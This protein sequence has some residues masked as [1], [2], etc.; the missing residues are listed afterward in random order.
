MCIIVYKP[1]GVKFPNDE[2]IENC[3]NHNSHGAGFMYPASDGV[4]IHKGFMSLKDFNEGIKPYKYLTDTPI[5]MHFRI[6]T[7]AGVIPEMTQPFPVTSKTKKLKRLDTMGQV[8]VAHNG[9]ISMTNDAK[10]ISDTAL[11]IKRYMSYLIKD[12]EYYKDPRIA[13]MIEQMIGSKMAVLSTDGHCE[14]LGSGWQEDGGIWYSNTTYKSYKSYSFQGKSA[15]YQGSNYYGGYYGSSYGN[16]YGS[17]YQ[18]W[19]DDDYDDYNWEGY[20]DSKTWDSYLEK[21]N[22]SPEEEDMYYDL[23]EECE[24][25]IATKGASCY[26]CREVCNCYAV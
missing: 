5:V 10:T 25:R 21:S 8:G 22:L 14:L 6:S 20:L 4:H 23:R 9:V 1:A 16:Y 19:D 7:H 2:I 17:K 13:E 3:F 11:F 12:S 18:I 15:A 24:D 26:A